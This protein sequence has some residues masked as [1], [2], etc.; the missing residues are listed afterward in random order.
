M[1]TLHF[2]H[3]KQF[4]SEMKKLVQAYLSENNLCDNDLTK[5]ERLVLNNFNQIMLKW[6]DMYLFILIN[7]DLEI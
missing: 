4:E 3:Q 2:R 7:S 5:N 1:T 6:I